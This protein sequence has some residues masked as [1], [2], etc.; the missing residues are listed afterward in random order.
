M[1]KKRL[2]FSFIAVPTKV[3][4]NQLYGMKKDF[5]ASKNSKIIINFYLIM[6]ELFSLL[7]TLT[8]KLNYNRF[9]TWNSNEGRGTFLCLYVPGF[10]RQVFKHDP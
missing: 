8:V 2:L 10:Q 9:I 6:I 7:W 4:T 5:V 1:K 3:K